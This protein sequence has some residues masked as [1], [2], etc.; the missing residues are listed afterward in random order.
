MIRNI[1]IAV[2]ALG[3]LGA[4]YY[5]AVK[6]Q[7]KDKNSESGNESIEL[8][9]AEE[10]D[11]SEI[12][13]RNNGAEYTLKK[14]GD[15]DDAVWSIPAEREGI[16]FSQSKLKNEVST[17]ISLTA[18]KEVTDDLSDTAA[19][20][21]ADESKAVTIR[22]TDGTETTFVLGDKVVVDANYYI[23]EK[24]G[25]KIY[26]ISEYK[27][28]AMLKQ[29]NDFRETNL[30]TIDTSTISEFSASRGGEKIVAFRTL[31]EGESGD[32][33]YRSSEIQ[34]TYPYDEPVKIDTFNQLVST[35][36]GVEVISFV[37]DDTGDAAKYGLDSG[38]KIFIRDGNGT[39]TLTFGNTD[40]S[41]NVYA[42][43][44][45]YGFI[46]TMAPDMLNAAEGIKPF[47]LIDKFAHIYDIT[48]VNS[49]VVS[50]GGKT[51]TMTITRTGSGDSEKSE[52]SVDGKSANE[53]AFKQAYQ[54]IIGLSVTGV[55]PSEK[56]G[57]LVCEVTFNMADGKA[58]KASYYEYD[59]RNVRVVRPDGKSYLMLKKY[60]SEM[61]D[62]LDKFAQDP[63]KK[64]E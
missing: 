17:L 38:Y 53:D 43:Y 6:W 56:Q 29:P 25:G 19:Y 27:A 8:F 14:T 18:T 63:S 59:E 30:G 21:L 24:G 3:L 22:K 12:L 36:S 4:A 46:F 42:M 33:A 58:Y 16:E 64:S 11:I 51:H 7:P 37:S 55:V 15:G 2:V 28:E 34:M 57:A 62:K 48:K 32:A 31:G 44:N 13:L 47:D 10:K 23:M 60:V 52:Y 45:D 9:S 40:E 20:G 41:G 54:E 26:T 50:Y 35:F 5:F 61:S 49:V 1:I 39:H